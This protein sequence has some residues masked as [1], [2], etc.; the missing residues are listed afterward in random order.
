MHILFVIPATSRHSLAAVQGL[1]DLAEFM[2]SRGPKVTLLTS[3][4]TPLATV[5][6]SPAASAMRIIR[7]GPR[8]PAAGGF[9]GRVR[10]ITHA[11]ATT[12]VGMAHAPTPDII[13]TVADSE[14]PSA[15]AVLARRIFRTTRGRRPRLVCYAPSIAAPRTA[16]TPT[17]SQSFTAALTTRALRHA[18]AIIVSG[19]DARAL[20]LQQFGRYVCGNRI[21][22]VPPPCRS[23]PPQAALS[24]HLPRHD[25][26]NVLHL[27]ELSLAH[28]MDTTAK[29]IQLTASGQGIRWTFAHPGP[30]IQNLRDLVGPT[31]WA[32]VHVLDDSSTASSNTVIDT[33]DVHLVSQI[34]ESAGMSF[35][36]NLLHAMASARPVLVVGPPDADAAAIVRDHSSGFAVPNGASE[37]L[38]RYLWQLSD[39]RVLCQ[40]LGN[41]ARQAFL[42]H[43]A[44]EVVC[45]K[46]EAILCGVV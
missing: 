10:H 42:R 31:A 1:Y 24:A 6:S 32:Y 8:Q 12:A 43:Y 26:L 15:L 40:T 7:V 4:G 20:L 25:G 22:V 41:N 21:H 29:A 23:L 18:D 5:H 14:G 16:S 28:D 2:A 33:A 44:P 13:V 39:D 17:L 35:P 9:L 45:S 46:F 38:A 34:D 36:V 3:H 30:R 37:R 11:T 19:H 27:G